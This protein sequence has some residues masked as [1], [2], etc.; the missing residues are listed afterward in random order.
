MKTSTIN[1][2]CGIYDTEYTI[3]DYGKKIVVTLPY[4]RW[5]NNSGSLDFTKS[6]IS[7]DAGMFLIR[8]MA[9]QNTSCVEVNNN[10][11]FLIIEDVCEGGYRATLKNAA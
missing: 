7:D 5:D 11:G 1:V 10:G 3:R 2:Q 4:I 6:T 9:D 8:A